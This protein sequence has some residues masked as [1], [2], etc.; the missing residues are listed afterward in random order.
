MRSP[1]AGDYGIDVLNPNPTVGPPDEAGPEHEIQFTSEYQLLVMRKPIVDVADQKLLLG[2]V[3]QYALSA[4]CEVAGD[5]LVA[6]PYRNDTLQ[7]TFSP[8]PDAADAL[9][10][11]VLGRLVG[12]LDEL[13]ESRPGGS[14][15]D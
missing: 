12:S 3:A 10:G 11:H 5:D 4:R 2:T 14:I 7:T 1:I 15:A 13:P 8:L 6:R 9:E